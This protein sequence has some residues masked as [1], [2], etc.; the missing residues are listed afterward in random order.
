MTYLIIYPSGGGDFLKK[1]SQKDSSIECSALHIVSAQYICT[2][3]LV[4]LNPMKSF[5]L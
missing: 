5:K 3:S 2:F 4:E 1:N